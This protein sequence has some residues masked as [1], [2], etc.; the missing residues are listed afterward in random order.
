MCFQIHIRN[1]KDF[2]HQDDLKS[3]HE[4]ETRLCC[5]QSSYLRMAV[6][7]NTPKGTQQNIIQ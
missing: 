7:Q 3:K 4:D 6:L 1:N 2:W 5:L